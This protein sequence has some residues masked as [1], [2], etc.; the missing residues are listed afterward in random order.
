M[1]CVRP[2]RA[3]ELVSDLV[4]RVERSSCRR[5]AGCAVVRR[6]RVRRQLAFPRVQVAAE[7]ELV[8]ARSPGGRTAGGACARAR[9]AA[10][11]WRCSRRRTSPAAAAARCTRTRTGAAAGGAASVSSSTDAHSNRPTLLQPLLEV[12]QQRLAVG[13]PGE[14]RGEVAHRDLVVAARGPR[15]AARRGGTAGRCRRPTSSARAAARPRRPRASVRDP[16]ARADSRRR[17]AAPG[18]RSSP[19]SSA[20]WRN[21]CPACSGQLARSSA[22][23][24][25]AAAPLASACAARSGPVDVD[26][27]RRP[28]ARAGRA[29]TVSA[30]ARRRA[31]VVALDFTSA[32]NSPRSRAGRAP[33]PAPRRS[34]R[35][36]SSR[37]TRLA[38]ALLE[39]A[40]GRGTV[41]QQLAQRRRARR[42]RARS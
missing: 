10:R 29:A 5:R 28:R 41:E 16:A 11:C 18:S 31:G 21:G 8:A 38:P 27:R 20:A 36:S 17:A 14:K 2:T 30:H 40:P 33:A 25:C 37:V 6:P 15:S 12:E 1:S 34:R 39:S 3:C 42:P 19:P 23:G 13:A 35:S 9:A 32:R 4:G 7:L 24:R 26:A 22:S